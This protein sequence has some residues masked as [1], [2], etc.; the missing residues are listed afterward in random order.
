MTGNKVMFSIEQNK[1]FHE[2]IGNIALNQISSIY[3][4]YRPFWNVAT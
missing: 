1:Y 3:S 4:V 2:L